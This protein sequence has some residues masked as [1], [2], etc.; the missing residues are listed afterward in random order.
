MQTR[1]R[2]MRKARGLTLQQ[3][4]ARTNTTAQTIQRL[5]TGNMTVSID[6]LEKLSRAL[7]IHPVD[8][9]EGGA[10]GDIP[11]LGRIE[12]NGA[13]HKPA[14]ALNEESSFRISIPAIDPV[15]ISVSRT[16]GPYGKDAILI[17]ERFYG[18]SMSNALGCDG[19]AHLASGAT[20]LR[21]IIRGSGE[22]FTLVPIRCEAETLYDQELEWAAR[23]IMQVEYY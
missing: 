1:I 8:L 21:R 2:Q 3:L 14:S 19:L 22:R 9:L 10:R 20:L 6:W 11:L 23:I 18:R 17:A 12:G 13:L 16:I 7:D 5:E 4:A 15:A